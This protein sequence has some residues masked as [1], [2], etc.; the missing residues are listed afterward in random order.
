MDAGNILVAA[1][2]HETNTFSPLP[3]PLESFGHAAGPVFGRN[4]YE[5][6]RGTGTATAGF[7]EFA[8]SIGARVEVPIVAR[9]MPS[10]AVADTAYEAIA[11]CLVDAVRSAVAEKRCD[12]L[13]LELHGAMVTESLDD[14][15]G[16]LLCRLR[17]V[18]PDLPIAL[19]LD[20]H[21]NVTDQMVEAPTAVVAYKTYPHLDMKDCARRSAEITLAAMRGKCRPVKAWGNVPI[22][23]HLQCMDTTLSPLNELMA[24]ARAVE[25]R[26]GVLAVSILPGFPLADTR[27]AGL[28]C[29]VVTDGDAE[30]ATSIKTEILSAAWDNREAFVH[31]PQ[32]L[33]ESIAKAAKAEGGPWLLL[34]IADTC[35]SGGTLDSVSVLREIQRQGLKDV[36]AAPLCDPGAVQRMFEQGVGAEIEIELGEKILTPALP[37]VKQPLCLKGRVAAVC[38]EDIIVKGPVFT[39]TRLKIGP[40]ALLEADGLQIVV[41]SNRIEPYDPGIFHCVGVDPRQKRFVVLKSRM[42]CKPAFMQFAKGYFD[43]NGTGVSTSDYGIFDY[44]NLRRPIFPFDSN[45][46]WTSD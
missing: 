23:A 46:A 1:V 33:S 39:G 18:A 5:Q 43:C 29:I 40:T 3:T 15:E 14:G 12:A 34:D 16:P 30:L 37:D 17:E 25:Q 22:L 7:I 44:Q 36:A 19:S 27:E 11:D 45:T 6:F 28:S 2:S 35:N 10:S 41:T 26:D 31:K 8:E 38:H 13:F 42:Q 24:L 21:A 9:A 4:A 20:F 32:S